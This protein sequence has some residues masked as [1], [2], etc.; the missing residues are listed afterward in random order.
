MGVI[1]WKLGD[2][3]QVSLR[4]ATLGEDQYMELF[5][6]WIVGLRSIPNY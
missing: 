2:E 1:S 3:F 5:E 6:G 4:F